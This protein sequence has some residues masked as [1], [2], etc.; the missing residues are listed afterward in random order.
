MKSNLCKFMYVA[1]MFPMICTANSRERCE[2]NSTSSLLKVTLTSAEKEFLP[3]E[4]IAVKVIIQNIGGS[5]IAVPTVMEVQDYWL[6]FL[7]KDSSGSIVRFIGP[8]RKII[9]YD[10]MIV[11]APSY[12]YGVEVQD[13]SKQ[14]LFDR[15]NSYTIQAVYG[16]PPVGRCVFGSLKSNIIKIRWRRF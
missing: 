15:R 12:L 7:I 14:Y 1:I 5:D 3:S 13:L 9:N 6:R 10:R 16:E 11:L 2:E 4:P 8:E